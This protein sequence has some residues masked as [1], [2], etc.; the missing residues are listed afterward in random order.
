[1]ALV[2][3]IKGKV[4][5]TSIVRNINV[6]LFVGHFSWNRITEMIQY[7]LIPFVHGFS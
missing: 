6:T 2:I 3:G 4:K 1:M 7:I 5:S